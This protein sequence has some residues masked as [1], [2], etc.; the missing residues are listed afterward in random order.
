MKEAFTYMFKDNKFWLKLLSLYG[1]GFLFILLLI[2]CVLIADVTNK[3]VGAF[4]LFIFGTIISILVSGYYMTCINALAAQEN[5][6]VIPFININ[7]NMTKGLMF[8]FASILWNIAIII[9]GV[10]SAIPAIGM[11]F[12]IICIPIIVFSLVGLFAFIY[13]FAITNDVF[14]FFKL[15]TAFF[16]IKNNA[17]KYFST[18]GIFISLV[19]IEN[20]IIKF[21]K[22]EPFSAIASLCIL[23]SLPYFFFVFAYLAAKC[24]NSKHVEELITKS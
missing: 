5:N 4:I 19:V 13:I 15:K 20:L 9:A 17:K 10:L 21:V 1:I 16:L 18:L 11:A 22:I 12:A 8:Y 6:I 7:K 2:I 24:I 23:L 14:S 3:Y